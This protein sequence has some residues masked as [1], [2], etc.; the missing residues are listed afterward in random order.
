MA[1]TLGE[2]KAKGLIYKGRLPPPKGRPEEDWEDREQLLFRS[3]EFGDDID[4]PLVKSDGGYT[5][6][7]ADM[8]YHRDKF[9]RGFKHHD[10]RVGRRP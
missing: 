10:R 1:E 5:Y 6:F 3:T 9:R 4:R 2:L 8:A 7:A